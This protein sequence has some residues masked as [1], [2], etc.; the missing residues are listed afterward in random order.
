MEGVS[1]QQPEAKASQGSEE[2]QGQ[3]RGDPRG[4]AIAVVLTAAGGVIGQAQLVVGLV[5]GL[6][7]GLCMRAAAKVGENPHLAWG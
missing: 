4:W 6:L 3:S 1:V 5:E 7:T 2:D